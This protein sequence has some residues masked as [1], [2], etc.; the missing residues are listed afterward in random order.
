[1]SSGEDGPRYIPPRSGGGYAQ[2]PQNPYGSNAGQPYPYTPYSAPSQPSAPQDHTPAPPRRRPGTVVAGVVL[3]VV[4]ALPFVVLGVLSLVTPLT[5]A[6]LQS[7]LPPDLNLEQTLAQANVT[8]DQLLQAL[9]L[10]FAIITLLALAFVAVSLTALTGRRW[11]R[12]VATVLGVLFAIFLVLNLSVSAAGL[13][14]AVPLVLL[15][16]GIVLLH[17][18]P[19]SD[20]FAKL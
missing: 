8:F 5:Q 15:I 7:V 9:R 14:V 20:W 3:L 4:A 6:E 10:M 1:M 11:A 13:V 2:Y 18:R 17:R 16:A 19:S 12:T